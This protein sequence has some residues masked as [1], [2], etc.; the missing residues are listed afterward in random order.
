MRRTVAAFLVLAALAVGGAASPAQ[1]ATPAWCKPLAKHDFWLDERMTQRGAWVSLSPSQQ[2]YY[3][4]IQ[5]KVDKY[6]KFALRKMYKDSS[7]TARQL[8][9]D[10]NFLGTFDAN[11]PMDE[12]DPYVEAASRKRAIIIASCGFD[13]YI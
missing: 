8:V 11:L 1:A 12:R 7:P 2:R 4:K 5:E 13:S 10:I 6:R 9:R 3:T